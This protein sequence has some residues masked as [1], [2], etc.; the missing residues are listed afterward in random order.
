MYAALDESLLRIVGGQQAGQDLAFCTARTLAPFLEQFKS[1]PEGRADHSSFSFDDN[2]SVK[3][4][5]R[6]PLHR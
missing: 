2:Y 4:P 1:Q 5:S 6:F 3:G